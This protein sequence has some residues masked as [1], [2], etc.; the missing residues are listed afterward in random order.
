MAG[1]YDFVLSAGHYGASH[2]QPQSAITA[3][4]AWGHAWGLTVLVSHL[5]LEAPE[6]DS[7]KYIKNH[8]NFWLLNH[9]FW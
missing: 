1:M 2:S 3:S 6:A 7:T 9:A 4:H 5:A 8:C